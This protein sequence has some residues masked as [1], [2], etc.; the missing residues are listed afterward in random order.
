MQKSASRALD[1]A[2]GAGMRPVQAP[3]PG[4]QE[5][6]ERSTEGR[7]SLWG[8]GLAEGKRRK[9]ILDL[10]GSLSDPRLVDRMCKAGLSLHIV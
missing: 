2:P 9:N 1:Y 5:H 4:Q 7:T 8:E 6:A 10:V 3:H